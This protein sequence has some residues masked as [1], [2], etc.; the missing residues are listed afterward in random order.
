M[1]TDRNGSY[2]ELETCDFGASFGS[3]TVENLNVPDYPETLDC[4]W[5]E[6]SQSFHPF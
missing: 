4:H 2:I 1:A 3:L 6:C 5:K